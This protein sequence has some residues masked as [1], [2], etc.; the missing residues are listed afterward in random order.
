MMAR[1]GRT[2]SRIDNYFSEDRVPLHEGRGSICHPAAAWHL[3]HGIIL[4]SQCPFLLLVD[5]STLQQW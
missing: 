5:R 4:G 2:I 1:K 3:G